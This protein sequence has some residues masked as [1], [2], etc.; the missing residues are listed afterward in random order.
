MRFPYYYE[1]T[2]VGADPEVFLV[3]KNNKPV[4]AEGKIGGSKVAPIPMVG[5]P[6]GFMVQE[7][8]V[9]AEYN[10]PVATRAQDFSSNILKGLRYIE[11]TAKQHGLK[12]VCESALHFDWSELD[13]EHAQNLGCSPDFN[14]WTRANNRRP[15]PP[16]SLRT[17]AGHVHIGW[18]KSDADSAILFGRA[19]DVYLGIPS[20]LVTKQN[21]R[22]NLYGKAGA[23]RIKDYGV[24]CRI[25]DNFWLPNQNQSRH[26][27]D[28]CFKIA[29]D[30]NTKQEYLD[31]EL[32]MYEIPI[33]RAI[34]EHNLDLALQMM[35][36]FGVQPFPDELN[37]A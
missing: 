37:A 31:E 9:A 20:L 33:Q 15:Q 12:V 23:I 21:E 34:N 18:N 29:D 22:R 26:I 10:I 28:T 14:A 5:L 24:E 25:L 35:Q 16:Q 8:N 2:G 13:T 36:H 4:S 32:E 6:V 30:L 1:I 7:D 27:Y 17:A 11:K 3:D 19:F